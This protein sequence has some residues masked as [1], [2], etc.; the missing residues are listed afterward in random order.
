MFPGD[1]SLSYGD[2]HKVCTH[3]RGGGHGE[4]DQDGKVSPMDDTVGKLKKN[5][6]SLS[7]WPKHYFG[8]V[9][10]AH[11]ININ[12]HLYLALC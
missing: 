6:L 2:I 1:S 9:Q 3:L 5:Y 4:A 10:G 8:Q 11:A 7:F 12:P